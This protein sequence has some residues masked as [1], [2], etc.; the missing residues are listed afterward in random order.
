MRVCAGDHAV[1]LA[2]ICAPTTLSWPVRPQ[3][4]LLT[5]YRNAVQGVMPFRCCSE[6]SA[7]CLYEVALHGRSS[8]LSTLFASGLFPIDFL[9]ESRCSE[10]KSEILIPTTCSIHFFLFTGTKRAVDISGMSEDPDW[11]LRFWRQMQIPNVFWGL[12]FAWYNDSQ[13]PPLE[14]SIP[15]TVNVDE[16][17]SLAGVAAT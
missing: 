11:V 14:I 10:K 4:T 3:R 15:A 13:N 6:S 16:T 9:L 5:C 17:L 12:A 7:G 1:N 2:A 8:Q